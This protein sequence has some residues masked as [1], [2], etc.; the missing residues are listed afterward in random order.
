[1]DVLRKR[2]GAEPGFGLFRLERGLKLDSEIV[3]KSSSIDAPFLIFQQLRRLLSLIRVRHSK[4]NNIRGN[5]SRSS[6]KA[7]AN[8]GE[9]ARFSLAGRVIWQIL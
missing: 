7:E 8:L 4:M 1:M 9:T 5:L 3:E 6:S 2:L